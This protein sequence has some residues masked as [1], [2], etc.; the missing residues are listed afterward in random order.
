MRVL[1]DTHAFIWWDGASSRL[2]PRVRD[3][4]Y[5]PANDLFI[6]VASLWEM[7][8]KSLLR[9]LALRMPLPE[10]VE[11][12]RRLNAFTLVPV[13]AQHVFELDAL[14]R[15]HNDPFDRM[16]IAQARVEGLRLVTNDSVVREYD[17]DVIW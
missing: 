3:L 17:V 6:S 1:L 2:S 13:H 9:K 7:Q 16:L 12:Q 11:E 15:I 5:D 10:L 8:I 4:C 14:P